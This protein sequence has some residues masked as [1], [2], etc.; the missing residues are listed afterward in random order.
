MIASEPS[1]RAKASAVGAGVGTSASASTN[2]RHDPA[3]PAATTNGADR[4]SMSA[5]TQMRATESESRIAIGIV[6]RRLPRRVTSLAAVSVASTRWIAPS[7]RRRSETSSAGST[8]DSRSADGSARDRAWCNESLTTDHTTH[9][10]IGLAERRTDDELLNSKHTRI[11]TLILTLIIRSSSRGARA[12]VVL[13]YPLPVC[14][15]QEFGVS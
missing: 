7:R 5:G 10:T 12:V 3:D 1:A 8:Q 11:M 6:D 13:R 14:R 15:R 9:T 4:E 2:A